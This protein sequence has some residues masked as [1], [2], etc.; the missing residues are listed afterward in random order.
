MNISF[1][2]SRKFEVY[3]LI[4]NKIP[5]AAFSPSTPPTRGPWPLPLLTRSAGLTNSTAVACSSKVFSG[6]KDDAG[7]IIPN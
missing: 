4:L 3:V 1:L 6:E 7:V 5:P 2:Y